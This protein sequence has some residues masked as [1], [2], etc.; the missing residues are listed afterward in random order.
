MRPGNT[1]L[2]PVHSLRSADAAAAG[3]FF[4]N[5]AASLPARP[6]SSRRQASPPKAAGGAQIAEHIGTEAS[7]LSAS[8]PLPAGEEPATFKELPASEG[9]GLFRGGKAKAP[10]D[11]PGA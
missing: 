10:G 1:S 7:A 11:E 3:L 5:P 4:P 9:A 2:L 6:A 8:G